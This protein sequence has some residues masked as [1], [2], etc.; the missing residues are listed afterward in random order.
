[1]LRLIV[2]RWADLEFARLEREAEVLERVME[3]TESQADT[4][5]DHGHFPR[6]VSHARV[7]IDVEHVSAAESARG[8]PPL[9]T[10]SAFLDQETMTP[11]YHCS[12]TGETT[13]DPPTAYPELADAGN[14]LVVEAG[15]A[16]NM[17]ARETAVRHQARSRPVVARQARGSSRKR[18]TQKDAVEVQAENQAKHAEEQAA[19]I[20]A[21]VQT[22][23]EAATALVAQLRAVLSDKLD[24]AEAARAA[25]QQGAAELHIEAL[26]TVQETEAAA[27]TAQS[28]L[29]AALSAESTALEAAEA[30]V[31][32]RERDDGRGVRRDAHAI[33]RR[34]GAGK[35]PAASA[36]RLIADV[37]DHG[38]TL[39][40]VR[41]RIKLIRNGHVGGKL[42]VFDLALG[43]RLVQ[44]LLPV[45]FDTHERCKGDARRGCRKPWVGLGSPLYALC[46][47]ERV[48]LRLAGG[49]DSC[50]APR[51]RVRAQER[52]GGER[53]QGQGKHFLRS[54]RT[55]QYKCV[56]TRGQSKSP[57]V[58]I[59]HKLKCFG[60][61]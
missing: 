26:A 25:A 27:T 18:K 42:E 49:M 13:W 58:G 45:A 50:R 3:R 29:D 14:Q 59:G 32:G 17:N 30:E 5:T 57:G 20:G 19:A 54:L 52:R 47:P 46:G 39:W 61:S 51:G 31:L 2:D 6:D 4:V 10:W 37:V 23:V 40:P 43:L 56:S 60:Q 24:A 41:G 15:G 7:K 12:V 33:R 48:N 16:L 36:R 35:G 55:C 44:G 53:C 34:L 38:R 28:E 21:R 1:M 9:E 11:Y 8:V 22:A